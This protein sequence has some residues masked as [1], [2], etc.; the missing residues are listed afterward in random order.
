MRHSVL[1]LVVL[2]PFSLFMF[3][4]HS[5]GGGGGSSGGGGSHGGFSGGS[6]GGGSASHSSGGS[7]SHGSA[8]HGT[9][10]HVSSGHASSGHNSGPGFSHVG[11]QTKTGHSEKRSFFS[12]LRHPFRKAQPKE[13][14]D[15]RRRICPN[16]RCMVCPPGSANGRWGCGGVLANSSCTQR[17]VWS[18]GSC[19]YH[20]P[21]LDDC[22]SFFMAMERQRFG[23]FAGV[24][25][26]ERQGTGSERSL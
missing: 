3:A 9:S 17:G 21:F 6:S 13:A 7:G 14:V 23:R 16:G 2:L 15:F 22:S 1:S 25:R 12:V 8:S 24:H 26:L 19:L 18:G 11:A 10:G 20:T 5:A 4:Q